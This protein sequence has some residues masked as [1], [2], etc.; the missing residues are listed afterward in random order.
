MA[1]LVRTRLGFGCLLP[2]RPPLELPL[3]VFFIEG[4]VQSLLQ[5]LGHESLGILHTHDF[6]Q[7]LELLFEVPVGS[8][9][10]NEG[11]RSRRPEDTRRHPGN[12]RLCALGRWGVLALRILFL[13][14][15]GFF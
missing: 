3:W 9:A 12:G 10:E 1:L 15:F 4:D 6:G 5:D 2:R 8:E 11:L 7:S 13:W 14:L